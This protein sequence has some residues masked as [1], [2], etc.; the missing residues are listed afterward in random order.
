MMSVLPAVLLLVFAEGLRR[1]RRFAWWGALGLNV[2]LGLLGGVL[3]TATTPAERLVA[4]GGASDAE[5]YAG[6]VASVAQPL[7]VATLLIATQ[8]RYRIAAPP[9]TYWRWA[10][11]LTATFAATATVFLLGAH[12]N[13][14]GFTPAPDWPGLLADLPTRFLPPGYLGELEITFLPI[15]PIAGALYTW[16]GVTFWAVAIGA[17]VW[18]LRRTRIVTGDAQAARELLIG[19]GGSTLSWLTTW[20]GNSYWFDSERGA[21][22]AYR[23]IGRV[24]L[25]TGEPFGDNDARADAV[26]GFARFCAE[27]AWTPCLYSV[28]EPTR[29]HT[30]AL[31]WHSVQVAEEAVVPL[32]GLAFTGKKWQ[33]VRTAINHATRA[34]VTAEWITYAHTP[35]AIRDQVRAISEEWIADKGLPE[36]GFTLGGLDELLDAQVRCLI[37]VDRD[38]TVHGITSWLPVYEE[39]KLAGW[40][41]DFMR[42]RD[43][44]FRGVMEFLIASAATGFQQEGVHLVSLSGAPLARQDRGQR[45]D[46]LQRLLDRSGRLLEPIYGFGSLLAFKAKFQ[47]EY[48]PLYMAYPDTA[49]LP[50]IAA[51]IGRAYL[52]H[53]GPAHTIR[54][55]RGRRQR[56]RRAGI[57]GCP[58]SAGRFCRP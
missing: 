45:P 19:R 24:A 39:G 57:G 40:T 29:K 13:R 27:Q 23:V 52:P 31:G 26:A 30:D 11:I 36:M 50:A 33:D 7:A 12:L 37:A 20:A 56:A 35:L 15:T 38:R 46:P 48:R 41:L 47:P 28:G 54:L 51:A 44:G 4:L 16:T 17:S 25:T 18:V 34:H 10:A 21:A 49:A 9:G 22:I 58:R 6:A 55:L 5:F 42:R 1:G 32:D 3:A 43:S 14:D 8:A 2:L 53:L